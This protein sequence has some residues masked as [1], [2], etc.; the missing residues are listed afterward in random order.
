ME[1]ESEAGV[2]LEILSEKGTTSLT[3]FSSLMAAQTSSSKEQTVAQ[4]HEHLGISGKGMV[5]E[6]GTILNFD[7][8]MF[9]PEIPTSRVYKFFELK[10]KVNLN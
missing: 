7:I 3:A 4:V 5:E 8:Y 6:V 2:S 1:A 10:F 9:Y